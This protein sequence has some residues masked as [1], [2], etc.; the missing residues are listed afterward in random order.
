MFN[1][2]VLFSDLK[3]TACMNINGLTNPHLECAVIVKSLDKT[4][5]SLPPCLGR[6]LPWKQCC[7]RRGS[8]AQ[9]WAPRARAQAPTQSKDTAYPEHVAARTPH[10]AP[11]FPMKLP[12]KAV[13]LSAASF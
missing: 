6:G 11:C 12:S 2:R 9:M 1:K 8:Q 13:S 5:E 4:A 7:L 10:T 3:V